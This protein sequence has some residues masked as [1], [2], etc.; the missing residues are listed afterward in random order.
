MPILSKPPRS[1]IRTSR[2]SW[3]KSSG[4]TPTSAGRS[5]KP[6]RGNAKSV[7]S[8]TRKLRATL[9]D[10]AKDLC[11]QR[12]DGICRRCLEP[13]DDPHHIFTV[14]SAPNISGLLDNIILLCRPCHNFAHSKPVLF[15]AWARLELGKER[16]EWLEGARHWYSLTPEGYEVLIRVY[17]NR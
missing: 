12:D 17:R 3:K 15:R 14:G 1:V 16:F 10:L 5:R 4:R 6:S 13:G 7:A 11:R 2:S 8:S 9:N